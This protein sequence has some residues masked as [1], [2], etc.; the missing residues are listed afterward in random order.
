MVLQGR[1][2]LNDLCRPNAWT[3]RECNESAA[4]VGWRF[5]SHDVVQARL[6]FVILDRLLKKPFG[7]FSSLRQKHGRILELGIADV[8]FQEKMS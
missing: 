6:S 5:G 2:G 4:F 3:S 1:A 8:C 7:A